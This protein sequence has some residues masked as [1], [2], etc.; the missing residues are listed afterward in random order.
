MKS[1]ETVSGNRLWWMAMAFA[2]FFGSAIAASKSDGFVSSE[3]FPITHYV[4]GDAGTLM[5]FQWPLLAINVGIGIAASATL[6]W[7]RENLPTKRESAHFV[8]GSAFAA[9]YAFLNTGLLRTGFGL[10]GFPIPYSEPYSALSLVISLLNLGIGV[11]CLYRIHRAFGPVDMDAVYRRSALHRWCFNVALVLLWARLNSPY[12][13]YGMAYG[14]FP[15]PHYPGCP[16]GACSD[17]EIH[18]AAVALDIVAGIGLMHTLNR[19]FR[20]S[21]LWVAGTTACLWT[22]AN[23]GYWYILGATYAS[24]GFP[25]TVDTIEGLSWRLLGANIAAGLVALLVV[26]RLVFRQGYRFRH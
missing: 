19:Y 17:S 4:L 3:G 9:L 13:T 6:F 5:E 7:A 25:F 16:S 23:L 10:Y 22:W 18:W 15:L 21:R 24:F 12:V 14:G 26:V 20:S 2:A 8:I 1:A 11:F